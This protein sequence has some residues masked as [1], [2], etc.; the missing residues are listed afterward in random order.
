MS[1][2]TIAGLA[3]FVSAGAFI[4][5]VW[6]NARYRRLDALKEVRRVAVPNLARF[7]GILNGAVLV[8]GG[9]VGGSDVKRL[10]ILYSEVRN[11]YEVHRYYFR[12]PIRRTIDAHVTSFEEEALSSGKLALPNAK[13]FKKMQDIIDTIVRGAK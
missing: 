13:A 11:T 12:K 1:D 5:T 10:A 9:G 7:I 4:H 6:S 2:T 3:L 8:D